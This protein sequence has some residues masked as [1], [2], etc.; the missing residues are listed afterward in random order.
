MTHGRLGEMKLLLLIGIPAVVALSIALSSACGLTL[1]ASGDDDGSPDDDSS[2]D[3]DDD[4]RYACQETYDLAYVKCELWIADSAGSEIP[5]DS[6]IAACAA[7]VA[8]YALTDACAQC[9]IDNSDDCATM[10]NCLDQDC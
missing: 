2:S 10:R 7:G 3:D 8:P 9:V 1:G 5:E 6:I 4:D